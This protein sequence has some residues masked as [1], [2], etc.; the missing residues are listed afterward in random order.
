ML[1]GALRRFG[2]MYGGVGALTVL[3]SLAFGALAGASLS[4]SIAIGLYLVG[5]VI[6]VFGFFVGNRGPFRHA[7]DEGY[8]FLPRGIRRATPEERRESMSVSVLFVVLGL[9]LIMLGVVSDSSHKLF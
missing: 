3:L 5:S 7:H 4:R 6:L 2:L 9:G 1:L 8:S